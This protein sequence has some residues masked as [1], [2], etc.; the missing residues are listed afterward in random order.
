M[1][2]WLKI[3]LL[4][5]LPTLALIS[6]P[7]KTLIGGWIAILLVVGLMVFLGFR[8]VKGDRLAL[9]FMILLQGMNVVIRMM[10]FANN[11]MP[12]GGS[13]DVI[14]IFTSILGFIL[15][16]YLVVRLDRVDVRGLLRN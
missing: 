10:M 3:L 12:A 6:Y 15:S 4:F 5:I 11:A 14:Y 1:K 2:T 9:T 7:P 8:I 13:V 16:F